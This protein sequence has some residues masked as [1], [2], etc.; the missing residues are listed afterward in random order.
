MSVS[1]PEEINYS[2]MKALPSQTNTLNVAA[3]PT[4]G[5]S[6]GPNSN[7]DLQLISR[8]CLIP[9]SMYLSFDMT[10][11]QA[12][13]NSEMKACPAYTPFASVDV[14]VGSQS[15]DRISSYNILMGMLSNLTL[16]VAQKFGQQSSLGYGPSTKMQNADAMNAL[17]GCLFNT[18]LTA[19]TI[20]VS[21]PLMCVLSQ[22]EKLLPLF[23][24]PQVKL[25]LTVDSINSMFTGANTPSAFTLSNVELRYKTVDFGNSVESMLRAAAPKIVIKSQSYGVSSQTLTGGSSGS[26]DLVFNQRYASVKALFALNGSSATNANGAF[27]SVNLAP[28]SNYAFLVGGVQYPQKRL[29]S[30]T[31]RAAFMSELRS[32][33]GSVHDR[34]NALSID[35]YEFSF[36]AVNN[37]SITYIS[38]AK[39]YVATSTERIGSDAML[40]GIS[41]EN[42][43]ITYS[44]GLGEATTSTSQITLVVNHDAI[45]EIDS[46]T[47]DTQLRV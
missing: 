29:N 21:M 27:D 32:A 14:L 43:P 9:D 15:I 40:T 28:G 25:Q 24:M 41:T 6:F 44:I 37:G 20:S 36:N 17:D 8:G 47:G 11:A 7:I 30:A 18:S 33:V 12:A 39:F 1:L 22:A 38:P 19:D 3:T 42:T 4:N 13:L 46:V 10:I 45:F 16:D 26:V 35:A 2:P 34:T 23:L 5:S 31:N